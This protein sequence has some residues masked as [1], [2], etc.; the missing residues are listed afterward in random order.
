MS[1]GLL[2]D[3]ELNNHKQVEINP[4]AEQN[5]LEYVQ[6]YSGNDGRKEHVA[7]P[8][9]GSLTIS[10]AATEHKIMN[11]VPKHFFVLRTLN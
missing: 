6:K 2:S 3:Y 8:L 4:E 1:C 9:W 7:E 10:A 5:Q 11:V